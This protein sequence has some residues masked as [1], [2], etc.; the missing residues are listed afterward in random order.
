MTAIIQN[1][2]AI[3]FAPPEI[4]NKESI[5]L[6]NLN[7]PI[8]L[9]ISNTD[10]RTLYNWKYTPN[11]LYLVKENNRD[12]NI[13]DLKI[14]GI[15]ISSMGIHTVKKELLLMESGPEIEIILN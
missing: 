13:R 2:K 5:I 6:F 12:L 8:N 14:N 11:L 1:S 9:I 4:V 15:L 10:I 7:E 3:K